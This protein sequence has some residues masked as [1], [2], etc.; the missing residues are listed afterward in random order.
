MIDY[1]NE[2]NRP[3]GSRTSGNSLATAYIKTQF[4]ELLQKGQDDK[5]SRIIR[6]EQLLVT[7]SA[8]DFMRL[9]HDP[10]QHNTI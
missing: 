8:A 4:F 9:G 6:N 1:L 10:E 3:S 2:G 7:L 5:I